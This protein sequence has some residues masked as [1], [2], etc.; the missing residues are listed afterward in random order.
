LGRKERVARRLEGIQGDAAPVLVTGGLVAN[1]MLEEDP[2]RY[3]RASDPGEARLRGENTPSSWFLCTGSDTLILYQPVCNA[4]VTCRSSDSSL[5]S[6]AERI[7]RYKAE[8][9]RQLS[10]RYG[11]LLDQEP[12]V[13]YTPQYRSW[14]DPD[15]CD[16]PKNSRRGRGRQDADENGAEPRVAY[17]SGVGRV[18]MRTH[19]DQQSTS[20]PSH[21]HQPPPQERARR[22]SEQEKVMNMENYHRGGVQEKSRSS[23][24]SQEQHGPPPPQQHQCQG[25]D[26]QEPSSTSSK[27]H[28]SLT[29]VLSSPRSSRRASLP[30]ARYGISP[31]DLFIEQQAQSILSRQGTHVSPSQQQT[32]EAD[33]EKL[34]DRAKM[35]VAAK[36]SL[37]RELERTSEGAVPKPRSRNAAVERRMR[38]VQDRAHTQPVTSVEVVNAS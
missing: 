38:R 31:G 36:R 14:R 18:Y 8:R 24:K 20:S 4:F 21:T 19:P 32:A 33:E 1:R 3:T 29:G 2:P 34:D 10:E 22:A 35:S 25:E 37:F 11:I 6:K 27:D 9:R 26:H 5:A 12:E 30:A 7:A 28:Q 16:D 15:V 13:E 23:R 17:R